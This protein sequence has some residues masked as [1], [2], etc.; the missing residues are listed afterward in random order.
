MRD[1]YYPVPP[2]INFIDMGLS[3]P[4]LAIDEVRG[5]VIRMKIYP[6]VGNGYVWVEAAFHPEVAMDRGN[7]RAAFAEFGEKIFEKIR[8]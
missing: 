8:L 7:L 6:P 4:G 5:Y 3:E 1:Y 2:K